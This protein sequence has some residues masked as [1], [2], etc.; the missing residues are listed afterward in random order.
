MTA[1]QTLVLVPGL[2]C[3]LAFTWGAFRHFR[4]VTPVPLG[5]R[6][7]GVVSLATMTAFT[8]AVLASPMPDTWPA[9]PILSAGSLALFAWAVHAT[10][11]AALAQAFAGV[12]PSRLVVTGPFR[13][14][15][16]P[17]YT[18]YLIFWLATFVATTSSICIGGTFILLMC[19]IVAAREEERLISRSLL[20][21]E[22][23]NYASKIG[24]F[25]PK[26]KGRGWWTLGP[27][28]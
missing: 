14:L 16:H 24:M 2:A 7:I 18:S 12:Q 5:M 9:A 20:A 8:G 19:Y 1:A 23:A 26:R 13:Y 11:G 21:T 6:V 22:Y 10:R 15:R 28:V 4:S 17:F 27:E 3:F 25:L